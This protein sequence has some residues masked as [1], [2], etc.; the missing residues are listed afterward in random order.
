MK[1]IYLILTAFMAATSFGYAQEDKS[2]PAK[3]DSK[4]LFIDYEEMAQFPGGEQECF[5]F[6]AANVRYP[7]ECQEQGIQGRVIVSFVINTDGSIE[8]IKTMRSPDPALSKEAERVVGLM[9]KW[10]PA[11]MQGKAVRS[12]FNLPIMF[13]LKT[14]EPQKPDSVKTDLAANDVPQAATAANSDD[15]RVYEVVE[16]NAQFPGGE[17][18]C[19][20]W[21]AQNMRYPAKAQE[22]GIQGRVIVSFV[23]NKDGS[24]VDVKTLRSPHSSLTKE[25]ERLVKSMPK[26]KPATQGSKTVRSRF[27]LPLMF[28]L[29]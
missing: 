1:R 29:K 18:E 25:A 28:S 13:R 6:L 7:A 20:K 17:Q 9:P 26:W 27:S 10:K 15:E 3:N 4:D 8:E 23:V 22:E 2:E 5:K 16:T 14:D 19:Y 24:I 21:L 12:R 11:M